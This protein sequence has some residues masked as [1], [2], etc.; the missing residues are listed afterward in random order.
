MRSIT[1]FINGE[2]MSFQENKWNYSSAIYDNSLVFGKYGTYA[3]VL[4]ALPDNMSHFGQPA[5]TEKIKEVLVD[6]GLDNG[7]KVYTN[8]IKNG[9]SNFCSKEF[10]FDLVWAEEMP[11][12][13]GEV[14]NSLQLIMECEWG[15]VDA[16][17]EDFK[18]LV[19][20][21]AKN[22][23]MIFHYSKES[24]NETSNFI[25][26]QVALSPMRSGEHI[27]CVSYNKD[28]K[29]YVFRILTKE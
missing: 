18:K 19:V 24:F 20:A 2:D 21:N 22:R 12:Y 26:E 27:L 10:M 15:G 3:R 9:D 11:S 4:N 29:D 25:K 16:I 17:K 5:R 7:S 6:L 28:F 14:I 8:G 13:A 1:D 23:V